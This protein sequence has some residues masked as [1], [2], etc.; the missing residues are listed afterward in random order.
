MVEEVER[1][2]AFT[3]DPQG[4]CTGYL[5]YSAMPG[6]SRRHW[7]ND[8]DIIIV[9]RI[10]ISK[11]REVGAYIDAWLAMPI[12]MAFLNPTQPIASKAM[13][14][15]RGIGDIDLSGKD[16]WITISKRC[17][18]TIYMV[19]RVMILLKVLMLLR[20]G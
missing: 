6:T 16:T 11:L 20:V 17:Q 18:R 7:G 2:G 1:F 14:P 13:N 19:F 3:H 5:K 4:A 15:N 12:S 10:T 8:I 9:S